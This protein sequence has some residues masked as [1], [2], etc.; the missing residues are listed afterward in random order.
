[1]PAG[2]VGAGLFIATFMRILVYD[3]AHTAQTLRVLLRSEGH[4]VRAFYESRA[5][6]AKALDWAPDVA[7]LDV[8]MPEMAGYAV[9]RD[10]RAHFGTRILL[11]A[12]TAQGSREGKTVAFKAGFDI[13]LVKPVRPEKLLYIAPDPNTVRAI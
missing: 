8:G 3:D 13:Y 9:A 12:V 4:E 7:F 10:M 11:I 2:I 6:L 5:F 1:M